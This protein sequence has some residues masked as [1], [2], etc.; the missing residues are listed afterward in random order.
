MAEGM[1]NSP[2]MTYSFELF[3][4][5]STWRVISVDSQH[6]GNEGSKAIDNNTSTFWHTEYAGSEPACP[7][8]LVV[9]MRKIYEVTAFTYTART[10]GT[11][12]GMVKQ[13]EVYLSEDGKTW[14]DPVVS[15]EFKNST[16]QQVATLSAPTRGRYLKFV[17]KSE[18]NGRAWSSAAEI[19][20]Q[21]SADVTG[22]D[23]IVDDFLDGNMN[24]YTL[25]GTRAD[26]PTPGNY[27]V[28]QGKKLFK[29]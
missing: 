4:N 3:I 8:T 29:K 12:N 23:G 21:A 15:G 2:T 19:G 25:N 7:H 14:G 9:D 26:A 24:Y 11:A 6:G 27:Y 18:I 28:H 13:Y 5:K 17:A 16:A 20:I 22:I 1:A 10:D